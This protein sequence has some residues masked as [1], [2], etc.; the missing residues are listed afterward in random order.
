MCVA[1]SE[2]V[3]E[4]AVVKICI[5]ILIRGDDVSGDCHSD[6][7]QLA[8]S[9]DQLSSPLRTPAASVS[10]HISCCE[11]AELRAQAKRE[12]SLSMPEAF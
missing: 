4:S 1:G 6:C 7:P 10:R 5:A 2:V 8:V 11:H 12:L 9:L 3:V